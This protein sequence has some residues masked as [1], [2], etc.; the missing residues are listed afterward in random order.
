MW[1]TAVAPAVANELV[2]KGM[3]NSTM[4]H[5]DLH[6]L[7][8]YIAIT[9]ELQRDEKVDFGRSY[10][11]LQRRSL[12]SMMWP[13]SESGSDHRIWMVGCWWFEFEYRQPTSCPNI[14]G[15]FNEIQIGYEWKPVYL[16]HTN[17]VLLFTIIP[18]LLH[19]YAFVPSSEQLP[20]SLGEELFWLPWGYYCTAS[21]DF[22]IVSRSSS[23]FGLLFSIINL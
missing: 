14:R 13:E 21:L 15:S 5:E 1:N 10:F 18:I 9:W 3:S 22:L 8:I 16:I 12:S 19:S 7:T 11:Y 20:N 2:S 6:L 4:P 23:T 17:F